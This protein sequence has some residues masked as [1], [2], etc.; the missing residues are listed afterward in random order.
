[1]ELAAIQIVSQ[2]TDRPFIKC[3]FFL[4]LTSIQVHFT[5]CVDPGT[6]PTVVIENAAGEVIVTSGDV[7]SVSNTEQ[8]SSPKLEFIET[9]YI[10]KLQASSNQGVVFGGISME[11]CKDAACETHTVKP[12]KGEQYSVMWTSVTV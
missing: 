12:E 8:Q 7:E 10:I 1:M 11:I 3:F 5:E 4:A 2:Q 6:V 9:D